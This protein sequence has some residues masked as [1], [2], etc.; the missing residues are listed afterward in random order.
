M[1][2]S[3]LK[4]S[5]KLNKSGWTSYVGPRVTGERSALKGMTSDSRQFGIKANGRTAKGKISKAGTTGGSKGTINTMP[6]GYSS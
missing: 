5:N 2:R 4:T 6:R 1:T 3:V